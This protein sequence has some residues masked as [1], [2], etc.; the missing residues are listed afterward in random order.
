MTTATTAARAVNIQTRL[1][2]AAGIASRFEIESEVIEITLDDAE[3]LLA[4]LEAGPS[5]DPAGYAKQNPEG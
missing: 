1:S 3:R 5:D 4:I 2:V